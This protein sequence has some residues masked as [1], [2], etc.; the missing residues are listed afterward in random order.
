MHLVMNMIVVDLIEMVL[1]KTWIE[2][3]DS[4]DI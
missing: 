1:N 4:Y 3:K 2:E